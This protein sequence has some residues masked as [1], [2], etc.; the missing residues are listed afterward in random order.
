MEDRKRLLT[1]FPS[2]SSGICPPGG[3]GGGIEG[4]DSGGVG[5]HK[6]ATCVSPPPLVNTAVVKPTVTTN[7][8]ISIPT[9]LRPILLGKQVSERH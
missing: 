2:N 8:P 5:T 9:K 7:N 1:L 4:S 3:G 6:A